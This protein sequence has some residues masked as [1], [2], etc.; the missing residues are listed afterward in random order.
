MWHHVALGKGRPQEDRG[1]PIVLASPPGYPRRL[2]DEADRTPDFRPNRAIIWQIRLPRV[3]MASLTRASLA[4]AGATFHALGGLWE[5]Q[6]QAGVFADINL[7]EHC[8]WVKKVCASA[9]LR[10]FLPPWQKSRR[11]LL[12]EFLAVGFQATLFSVREG[13]L[14]K[15]FLGKTLDMGVIALL[16]EQGVDPAG[17]QDEYH[18]VVTDGPL[19]SFPLRLATG[20]PVWREGHWELEVTLLE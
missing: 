6:V 16:Q 13:V 1:L 11:E 20:Q 4:L 18:T 7:Q 5:Q 9:G 2:S 8:A 14:D 10:P 15:A 19:F 12:A 17:G 3:L